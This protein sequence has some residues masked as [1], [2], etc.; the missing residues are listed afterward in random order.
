[1]EIILYPAP[2][3][4]WSAQ[5]D[6]HNESNKD[7]VLPQNVNLLSGHLHKKSLK[8]SN[9]EAPTQALRTSKRLSISA[10][11]HKLIA[12]RMDTTKR[13]HGPYSRLGHAP[14]GQ[15]MTADGVLCHFLFYRLG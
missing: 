2:A 11:L 13:R 4:R 12:Y 15:A 1:M 14:A 6:L 3:T 9:E 10:D 7:I 8:L 5:K